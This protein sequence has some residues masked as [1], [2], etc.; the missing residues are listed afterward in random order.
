MVSIKIFNGQMYTM[1]ET[2]AVVG[3]A[4]PTRRRLHSAAFK[5]EVIQAAMQP[6]VSMAAVALHYRL[7]A[8][9]VRSWI[10]A[11]K[12]QSGTQAARE[13]MNAAQAE[14]VPLRLEAPSSTPASTEIQIEVRRGG[15]MI[16]VRWPVT[17]ASDCSLWLQGWL[18]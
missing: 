16:T 13:S 12:A 14:F 15:A 8:N 6:R 9:M 18:R 11:H 2:E 17:A 3:M 5:A 1:D 10:S 4:Q 7:N